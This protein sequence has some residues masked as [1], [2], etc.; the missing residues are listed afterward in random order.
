MSVSHAQFALVFLLAIIIPA[1]VNGTGVTKATNSISNIEKPLGDATSNNISRDLYSHANN[2]D[3]TNTSSIV[4]SNITINE[5]ELAPPRNENG[6]Q[7]IELYNPSSIDVNVT[8]FKIITEI[9][10]TEISMPENATITAHGTYQIGIGNNTLSNSEILTLVNSTGRQSDRT[11][12]LVDKWSDDRTWQRIPD[13]YNEWKFATATPARLNE[14]N[15]TRSENS[16][17]HDANEYPQKC[18]GSAGCAEGVAIRIVDADTLY[19]IVNGTTYRIHLALT[20]LTP[21]SEQDSADAR[22]FTRNLC[23]GSKAL[24]DQDDK[25]LA[26]SDSIIAA[27]YCSGIN[28]NSELLENGY[29]TL[30][31]D[32]CAASE[33][34]SQPW[35]KD[36]GC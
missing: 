6:K 18:L 7:W 13:G 10:R 14:P 36:H 34:A 12:L 15:G 35:A 24:V 28:L 25:L 21:A 22:S 29:A 17:Y 26:S 11:P 5:V 9:H 19:V 3:G 27:V 2:L 20:K 33:F 23:L 31:K 1:A 4:P 30:D 8:N 16:T 32:Q